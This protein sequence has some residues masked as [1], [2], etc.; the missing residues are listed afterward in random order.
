MIDK[1]KIKEEIDK[2]FLEGKKLYFSMFLLDP[3]GKEAL[4]KANI[5]E[6]TLPVFTQKY[7]HWYTKSHRLIEKVAPHRLNDFVELYKK[8]KSKELSFSNYC[9]SD[10]LLGYTLT[11]GSTVIATPISAQ[12]K[13]EQ[14]VEILASIK[15]LVDDYFFNLETE[16]QGNIFDSELD[17]AE[18]LFKKK[19]LRAAGAIAGVVLEK[20]LNNVIQN[21]SIKLTKKNPT[22]SDFNEKLKEGNFID[23]PTWRK[24]QYLGDLRNICCHD[25]NVE[26][27]E[28]Q[29]KD[30]INGVKYIITNIF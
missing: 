21:H 18:E 11:S 17:A 24:I 7:N 6:S 3:K 20:H 4:K 13:M 22:I 9:I 30:L 8:A 15:N 12:G 10:A 5:D 2:L 16:L 25:K 19:F 14:Q 27:T 26:P 28:D 29:V 23:V 1:A